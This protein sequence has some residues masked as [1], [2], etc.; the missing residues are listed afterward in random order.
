MDSLILYTPPHPLV[1]IGSAGDG[2]YMICD[3]PG[4]YDRFLSGGVSSDI[5]FEIE[6]CARYPGIQCTAFDGTVNTLPKPSEKITFVKQNLGNG[7][8]GTTTLREYIG[9][10]QDVFL[11]MDIEGH[12]FRILPE[13]VGDTLNR[14]KQIV[15]EV[16]TPADI[17]KFPTY[18]AGLSDI[19]HDFMF[20][21]FENIGKTHTLVH[22]HP[23]N[24]CAIHTCN[25]VLLPNVFE[26][27]LV[28]NEYITKKV[29]NTL[30]LPMSF[31]S[32]NRVTDAVHPFIGYPFQSLT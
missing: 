11:K 28:R 23:N 22:V 9:D 2:G 4:T 26:C 24:A 12:E 25:N 10:H 1:R 5:N 20:N 7:S 19:T 14:V 3:L 16:H 32:P 18:Y 8:N 6:M 29:K 15:L 21:L 30:P 17:F 13:L 27:T 31:D